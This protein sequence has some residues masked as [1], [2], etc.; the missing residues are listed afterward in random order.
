M[1]YL[2]KYWRIEICLSHFKLYNKR[3]CIDLYIYAWLK[4][5]NPLMTLVVN[6]LDVGQPFN[7]HVFHVYLLFSKRRFTFN[8]TYVFTC[9]STGI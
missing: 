1:Q 7:F 5:S 3:I 9:L 6:L 2:F 4:N 8:V